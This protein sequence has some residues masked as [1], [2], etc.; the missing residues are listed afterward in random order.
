MKDELIS[1]ETA[2]LAKEKGFKERVIHGYVVKSELST[3]KEGSLQNCYHLEDYGDTTTIDWN[4]YIG[5][6][7]T[8]VSAPTQSLLQ[9]WLRDIHGLHLIIIPMV[10]M[11]YTFKLMSVWRKDFHP[12][13]LVIETP[14]YKGVDAFDY[15]DYEKALEAGLQEALKLIKI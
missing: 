13:D 15:D 10:T 4:N 3:I 12:D 7:V 11:T 14:P 5:R 9:R 8:N 6:F 2:R 1:F